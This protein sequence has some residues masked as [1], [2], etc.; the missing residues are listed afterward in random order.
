MADFSHVWALLWSA[1]AAAAAAYPAATA[2]I[3]QAAT[4]SS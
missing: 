4:Q 3:K 2:L 1:G